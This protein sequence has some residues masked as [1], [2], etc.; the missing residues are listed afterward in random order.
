[1]RDRSRSQDSR[2]IGLYTVLEAAH[3]LRVPLSTLRAGVAVL[4]LPESE[5]RL[6]SFINLVELHILN[7]IRHHHKI[8]L[9]KVRKNLPNIQQSFGNEHPL[10]CQRFYTQ[11]HPL[12]I[13]SVGLGVTTSNTC[14]LVI[15]E[16]LQM[17]L[18]RIEWD[19]S[20]LPERLY[21][22][23]RPHTTEVPKWIEI[24]PR[25][26]FGEPVVAGTGVCTA[27]LAQRYAAGESIDE[28]AANC[29]CDRLMVEEAIRYELPLHE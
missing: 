25:V 22:L 27:M 12:L 24:S 26:S 15:S 5:V 6:L 2:H 20:G 28:L 29:G 7:A 19:R 8:S 11:S 9:D 13:Q 16:T 17:Y 1:L 14:Q 4:Q 18:D 23:T 10:A 21:P 3:Y